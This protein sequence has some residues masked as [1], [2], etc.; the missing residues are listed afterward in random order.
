MIHEANCFLSFFIYFLSF[1]RMCVVK[2]N[3]ISVNIIL[4]KGKFQ[5]VS[6]KIKIIVISTEFIK[7]NQITKKVSM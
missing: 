3:F 1:V 6:I 2:M 7:N 4:I 5:V